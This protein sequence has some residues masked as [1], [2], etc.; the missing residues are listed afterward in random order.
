MLA[1]SQHASV[2]HVHRAGFHRVLSS[3]S[4]LCSC[5]ERPFASADKK[6]GDIRLWDPTKWELQ[7]SNQWDKKARF[8]ACLN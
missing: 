8:K 4:P 2:R 3:F 5:E 7:E 6:E 1:L